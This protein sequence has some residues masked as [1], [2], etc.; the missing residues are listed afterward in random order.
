MNSIKPDD[1][2]SWLSEDARFE[3]DKHLV[4]DWVELG[5]VRRT[6]SVD[7]KKRWEVRDVVPVCETEEGAHAQFEVIKR[8]ADDVVRY[9]ADVG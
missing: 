2:P 1:V 8:H 5:R 3:L 4:S 7:D 9:G 6:V